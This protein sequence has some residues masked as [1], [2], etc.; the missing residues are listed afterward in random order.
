MRAGNISEPSQP[1]E[2]VRHSDA[3]KKEYVAPT[4]RSLGSLSDLTEGIGNTQPDGL[5]KTK[6]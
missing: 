3:T 6:S 4:V 5:D 1:N 2:P